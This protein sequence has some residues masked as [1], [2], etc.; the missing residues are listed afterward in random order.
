MNVILD[1]E[2]ADPDDL[3]TL[4][5]LAHNP[6]V[7]LVAVNVTPGTPEQLGLIRWVF[8]ELGI[9]VPLGSRNPKHRANEPS[10]PQKY[11]SKFY[12]K[13]LNRR[14]DCAFEGKEDDLGYV[15]LAKTIQQYP[16]VTL[17]TG[18]SLHNLRFLFEN[19]PEIVLSRWVAQGGFAGDSVVP[20][21]HRLPKF[22]GRETCPT[23]NFNGDP[24]G[25]LLALE[26][27]QIKEKIL[28][29]KNVCHG[30][31]YDRKVHEQYYAV[32]NKNAGTKHIYDMMYFYLQNHDQKALH[33]PLAACVAINPS[34]CEFRN[35]DVYRSKGE[36]GSRLNP[37]SP[38]RIT[39]A[40]NKAEFFREFM[41]E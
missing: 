4:Y 11:V 31:V 40:V 19:Y 23:F 24:K 36:W 13:A 9:N 37:D 26:T 22:E 20:P 1:M 3:L 8:D 30:V 14:Y 27:P 7:N 12:Y 15:V 34:I 16:D 38:I 21:K 41:M 25:A 5:F 29:S 2:T 6:K 10:P 39:V 32:W 35:V 18:A 17:V 33:D 28:V